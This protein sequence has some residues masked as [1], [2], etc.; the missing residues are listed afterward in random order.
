MA[1][2][3][4][5]GITRA[6]LEARLTSEGLAR[7]GRSLGTSDNA[8]RRQAVKWGIAN[9]RPDKRGAIRRAEFARLWQSGMPPVEIAA[10]FG[11]SVAALY[12]AATRWGLP[13]ARRRKLPPDEE[14]AALR[15]EH[16]AREIADRYGV[17]LCAISLAL[18][19]ARAARDA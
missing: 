4:W 16:T 12:A 9:P 17:S 10:E 19:R 1:E 6:E 15:G 18:K 2:E 13:V 14:V 11:V 8:V 5:R 3:S 7:I